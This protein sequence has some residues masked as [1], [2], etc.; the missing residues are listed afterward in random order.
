MIATSW[1]DEW[2]R[3]G[4]TN[5]LAPIP[6]RPPGSK[7]GNDFLHI[8]L[9]NTWNRVRFSHGFGRPGEFAQWRAAYVSNLTHWSDW[10]RSTLGLRGDAV[11]YN[12]NANVPGNSGLATGALLSP[13]GSLVFGPWGETEFYLSGGFDSIP[14]TR[15]ARLRAGT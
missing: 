13:K 12:I 7:Y 10:F 5:Y 8:G 2:F 6:A 4:A 9:Y 3:L 1:A 15:G 11:R 14:T